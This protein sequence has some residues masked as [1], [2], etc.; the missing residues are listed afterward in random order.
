MSMKFYDNEHKMFWE[1]KLKELKQYGKTDAYYRA[2]VYVLSI[3]EVTR[4]H[5]DDIFSIKNGEINIDSLESAYQTGSSEKVTRMAFSLWNRCSYDSTEQIE[6]REYSPY[7]NPSE[8]FSCS[9]APYFYEEIKIRY[10]EYTKE[11]GTYQN[12]RV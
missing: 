3:C 11:R 2:I 1:R 6:R 10:P 7:Y 5:F 8:I 12:E 9:Y 4:E